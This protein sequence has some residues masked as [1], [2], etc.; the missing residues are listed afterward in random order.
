MIRAAL[1]QWIDVNGDRGRF[2]DIGRGP[3]VLLPAAMLILARTYLPTITR[4][5]RWFRVLAVEMPGS[6]RGSGRGEP[7]TYERYANWLVGFLNTMRID[8]A[9][10]I[11]HSCSGPVALTLAAQHP[12]RVSHLVLADPT[13]VPCSL[14]RILIG[15]AWGCVAEG[16]LTARGWPHV[17]FNLLVHPRN[18]GAQVWRAAKADLCT[19]AGEVRVPTL[20]A[21]GSQDSTLPGHVLAELRKAIPGIQVYLSS[22]GEHDFLIDRPA[23]FSKV[24]RAFLNPPPA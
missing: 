7:W 6:G 14:L 20:L 13:G 23:E 11:G 19:V 21:W 15:R 22:K 10:V 4:L 17:G 5:G 2:I 12:Q 24:V 8:T 3:T 16:E 1:E 18:F 9:A